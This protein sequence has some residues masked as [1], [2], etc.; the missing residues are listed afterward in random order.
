MEQEKKLKIGD[1][2]LKEGLITEENLKE[3]ILLQERD[4]E[5]ILGEILVSQGLL[6]KAKLNEALSFQ[7]KEVPVVTLSQIKLSSEVVK[8]ISEDIARRFN[9]IAIEKEDNFLTVA[10]ADPTDIILFDIVESNTGLKL[11]PVKSSKEE[12][13]QAIDKHYGEFPDM[14]NSLKE[15]SLMEVE[16]VEEEKPDLGQLRASAEDAPVIKFVNLLFLEAINKGTS[17]L[18][19]EPGQ[20]RVNVRF[21]IDGHLQQF[22]SPPK[23]MFLAIVSRI[24]II[25]GLNIAERRLPQDGRCR[26]K[27]KGRE[28]DVRVSTLPT[29]YGEKVVLRI[30]D[31]GMATLD[32]DRLG[33]EEE[34]LEK[35]KSCLHLPSGMFLLTG[36]TGSGKTSTLYAGLNYINEPNRN[37]VTVE[38]PVEYELE[39]INQVQV[40]PDIGVTFAAAL[41]H[42]LRQDPNVIMVGEI[43]D[44]ETAEMAIRA[45]LTGHL[46]L[47]TLHANSSI[48]AVSRLVNMGIESHFIASSLSLVIAQ[49]LIRRICSHCRERYSPEENVLAQLEEAALGGEETG[50]FYRG[51]GCPECNY[52][53]YRGRLGIFEVFQLNSEMKEIILKDGGEAALEKAAREAGMKSL[54]ER[55]LR[56][57]QEGLTSIEEVLGATFDENGT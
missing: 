2:L 46:V 21:R 44:R 25:S 10:T 11:R 55:G 24:K 51:K 42:I 36:P 22:V 19:I 48:A 47:S 43:R 32:V 54:R 15:L 57:A 30:L 18:H 27:I 50:V 28:I 14:E 53:G 40:R 4:E 39:G 5:K 17:D 35:V 31:K 20:H 8:I 16:K 9:L 56:K 52:V 1:I 12:I 29:I 41:R 6:D 23:R 7:R 37:I 49:R 26:L 34:D 33:M 38:D 13:L 3:A 45:A